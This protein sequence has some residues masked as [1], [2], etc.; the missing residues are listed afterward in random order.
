MERTEL[1]ARARARARV[2]GQ[3]IPSPG[4]ILLGEWAVRALLVATIGV[5]FYKISKAHEEL[6]RIP[7]EERTILN[8][9]KRLVLAL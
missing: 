6:Q 8:V 1:L 7:E 9:V 2:L 5:L 3:E 4:R